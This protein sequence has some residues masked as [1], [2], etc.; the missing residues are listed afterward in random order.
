MSAICSP[1]AFAQKKPA[2][3]R[4]TIDDQDGIVAKEDSVIFSASIKNQTN[5][6]LSGRIQWIVHSVAFKTPAIEPADM[7]IAAGDTESKEFLLRMQKHGFADVECRLV[8]DGIDEPVSR[9]SRIGAKPE[10]VKI[11]LTRE[12]DFDSFWKTSLAELAKVKPSF[13]VVAKPNRAGDEVEL[14]EVAM[15]SFGNVRV[16]GWLEVPKTK[17]ADQKFPVVIRVPGY[18]ENMRPIG[19]TDMI[20]FSFNVRGHGNSQQDVSS[21]P[22]DYWIRGLDDQNDYYYRGAYLD[23]VRAVDYVCTRDDVDTDRIAVWGGSQGGGFAFA[24]AALDPRVSLCVADIPFLCDWV[25]YFKLTH[26]PEMDQWI[27]DKEERTWATTLRTMSYFDT[28]NM[29]DRIKCPTIMGVGLQDQI[30]PPT[31]NFAAFNRVAGKKRVSDLSQVRSLDAQGTLRLGLET[32][33]K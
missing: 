26:W 30:C 25:N 31:T 14:F 18:G 13:Q 10:A 9:R 16:R 4:I 8:I 1:V 15:R 17:D 20:V 7:M 33:H 12:G 23:C 11:G 2:R 24:T 3:I 6:M 32:N 22:Q 19:R 5:R 27:A 29:C 21:K 28:I